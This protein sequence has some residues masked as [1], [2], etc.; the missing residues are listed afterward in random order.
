[1]LRHPIIWRGVSGNLSEHEKKVKKT[2]PRERRGSKYAKHG[3]TSLGSK[4]IVDK[5]YKLFVNKFFFQ[6]P[7][8]VLGHFASLVQIWSQISHYVIVC[9]YI[10]CWIDCYVMNTVGF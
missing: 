1:M 4:K 6:N 9:R 2:A 7:F 3:K 5:K 10:D 8:F